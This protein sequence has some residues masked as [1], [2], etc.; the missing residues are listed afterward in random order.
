MVG[1]NPLLLIATPPFFIFTFQYGGIKLVTK[2]T[3]KPLQKFTFQYGGIKHEA[4][5]A[6]RERFFDLHSSMVGLNAHFFIVQIQN[7]CIYIPVWWDKR[8]VLLR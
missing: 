7:F 1:L 2:K 5:T 8:A 4:L 3:N 6:D